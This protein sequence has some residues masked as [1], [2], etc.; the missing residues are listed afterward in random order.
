MRYDVGVEREELV[1]V[2]GRGDAHRVQAGELARVASGL[3]GIM[4][5]DT[6]ELEIWSFEDRVQR[7]PPDIARAP[8]NH[9]IGHGREI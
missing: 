3:V 1:D 4:D 8:L 9:S 5:P 2:V 7:E 6:D